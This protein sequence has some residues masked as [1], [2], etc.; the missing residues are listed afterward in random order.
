MSLAQFTD[1]VKNITTENNNPASDSS[2]VGAQLQKALGDLQGSPEEKMAKVAQELSKLAKSK[3]F[4]VSEADVNTYI[5]SLKVQYDMNPMIA[6]MA[7]TYCSS[8]CHFAS[9]ISAS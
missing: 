5:D 1:F 6:S 8:S 9:A 4:D 3:G 2:G 7:D